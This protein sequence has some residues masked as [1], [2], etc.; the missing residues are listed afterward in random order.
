MKKAIAA[1][2]ALIIGISYCPSGSVVLAA[3]DEEKITES[4]KL[5]GNGD[6]DFFK[7]M[8]LL[9]G[10]E[11]TETP[12]NTSDVLEEQVSDDAVE[13]QEKEEIPAEEESGENEEIDTKNLL[14]P[15]KMAVVIDP[16][17]MDGR[18]QIYSEQ[19]VVRNTGE[20]T[21]VLTMTGSICKS[22][23]Q[24][25]VVVRSDREGLHDN[26]VKS[27]YMEMEFD[28]GERIILSKEGSEYQKELEP[29][30][31]L[32]IS[33]SGEVNENA[34]ED[35]TDGDVTVDAVY[36]WD[37]KEIS[38]EDQDFVEDTENESEDVEPDE[39]SDEEKE[40]IKLIDMQ[41]P[42]SLDIVIDSWKV[43]EMGQILS[44]KYTIR[45]TGESAGTLM[46]SDL[47]CQPGEQSEILVQI[48]KEKLYEDDN[49]AVYMEMVSENEEKIILHQD[50]QEDI[51]YEI[52]LNPG[53]ET[54]I[55]FVGELNGIEVTDLEKGE[56]TVKAVCSWNL[57]DVMSE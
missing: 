24:E 51:R 36:S 26:E 44:E 39:M 20:T 4:V 49:Q 34:S 42:Q 52:R 30:E 33:F 11:K 53:E 50:S 1:V 48:E 55:Y 17:E 2:T 23:E 56:I 54:T 47:I 38:A 25:S 13:I 37:M 15:Q 12:K 6:L 27:V 43:D 10:N 21:G 7:N 35:W 5:P 40:E 8:T 9:L 18:G 45:N 29:G 22:Q 3:A 16:W 32:L 28:N 19:F 57:E 46:L 31:E 14:I 41:S